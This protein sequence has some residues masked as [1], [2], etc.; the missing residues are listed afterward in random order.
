M[1]ANAPLTPQ[2]RLRLCQRIESGWSITAAAE[3]MNVSRQCAHKWW[4]RYR[5]EGE[6]GLVDRSSRPK[7]C[8]H[9]TPPKVERREMKREGND[10][11]PAKAATDDASSRAATKLREQMEVADDAEWDVIAER[12]ANVTD[13]RRTLA[14]AGAVRGAA[15]VDKVKANGFKM[16]TATEAGFRGPLGLL[17]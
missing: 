9:Q 16:V 10:T 11:A 13:L 1:H 14:G 4:T 12:I 6:A 17:L 8:P 3:S 5:D 7:S 2:G 15:V